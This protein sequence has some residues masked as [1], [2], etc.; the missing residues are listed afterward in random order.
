VGVPYRRPYTTR[1]TAGNHAIEAGANYLDVATALGH[2]PHT[3]HKHYAE[4][5]QKGSVFVSFE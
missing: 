3:F 1:K 2:D 4:A 5:I